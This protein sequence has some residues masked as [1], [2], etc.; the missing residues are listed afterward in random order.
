M[1]SGP[2]SVGASKRCDSIVMACAWLAAAC[3]ESPP[4]VMCCASWLDS[5][6]RAEAPPSPGLLTSGF[7]SV[8][9]AT[10]QSCDHR[11]DQPAR[12]AQLATYPSQH[13]PMLNL[14][15]SPPRLCTCRELQSLPLAP[16]ARWRCQRLTVGELGRRYIAAA[17]GLRSDWGRLGGGRR[18]ARAGGRRQ[19]L[20]QCLLLRL[21]ALQRCLCLLQQ[22]GPSISW[23][24]FHQDRLHDLAFRPQSQHD[25][26]PCSY[27][28]DLMICP[29]RKAYTTESAQSPSVPEAAQQG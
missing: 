20:L 19:A 24:A 13:T 3:W 26:N 28:A 5:V 2:L 7:F 18:V 11:Q 1:V 8:P 9:A 17:V 21:H 16:A 22:H 23:P 14:I 27:K 4:R 15:R 6:S 10:I 12:P 25:A 29:G